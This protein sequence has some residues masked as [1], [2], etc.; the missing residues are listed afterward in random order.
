MNVIVYIVLGSGMAT[1]KPV[2]DTIVYLVWDYLAGA[3]CSSSNV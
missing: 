1:L 2:F 3:E